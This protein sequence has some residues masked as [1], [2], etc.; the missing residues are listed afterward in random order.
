MPIVNTRHITRNMSSL[1]WH[2]VLQNFTIFTLPGNIWAIKN[3][4]WNIHAVLMVT[5][6]EGFR[7][8]HFYRLLSLAI[9]EV[10]F[11]WTRF[12]PEEVHS[13]STGKRVNLQPSMHLAKRCLTAV[14][15]LGSF[16][17]GASDRRWLHRW[18]HKATRVYYSISDN[19]CTS[20]GILVTVCGSI[21]KSAYVLWVNTSTGYRLG[22]QH[23]TYRGWV[24]SV[25]RMDW[26]QMN[27]HAPSWWRHCLID[28][29]SNCTLHGSFPQEISKTKA[30]ARTPQSE[31]I[32]CCPTSIIL[33]LSSEAG[34]NTSMAISCIVYDETEGY[35][36]S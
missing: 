9:D 30:M 7:L 12:I 10:Q 14:A 3:I 4:I 6:L 18:M 15:S 34:L 35:M 1:G 20:T 16:W 23:Y 24:H 13:P 33:T 28:L 19:L 2:K 32:D 31:P 26:V 22:K 27:P 29:W 36:L 11:F 17:L 21:I 5:N 8:N 25:W